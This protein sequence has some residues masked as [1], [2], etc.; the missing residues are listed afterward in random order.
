MHSLGI[1]GEGRSKANQLI[2]Y[3]VYDL[4]SDEIPSCS[5]VM[6]PTILDKAGRVTHLVLWA[7]LLLVVVF[8]TTVL[9]WDFF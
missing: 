6:F 5:L 1:N 2:Q 9:L 3:Q 7:V 4:Q 8:L